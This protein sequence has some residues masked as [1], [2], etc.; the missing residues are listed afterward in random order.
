MKKILVIGSINVDF[1]VSTKV[2]PQIGETVMGEKMTVTYGG[3]GANQ[4]VAA[5]RLGANVSMIGKVGDDSIA[6]DV[7]SNLKKNKVS[8]EHIER[9]KNIET[10]SAHITLCDGDNSIIVIP[11]A[12]AKYEHNFIEKYSKIILAHTLVILQNEIPAIIVEAIIEFCFNN[13]IKT[14]YNPAPVRHIALD[15]L[16]KATYITPNESEFTLLFKDE[17]I[18][19]VLKKYPN[20]VI[21]TLGPEGLVYSNGEKIVKVP[22]H[23]TT[24]VDTT[25][26]GDTF[27]GA[28]ATFITSNQTFSQAIQNANIAAAIS[29]RKLGAQE[30]MPT[31]EEVESEN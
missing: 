16:V 29:I 12:N 2:R 10:G 30:G 8:T 11:A 26:A 18:E 25:G 5:A 19:D 3:K 28:F 7:L 9:L 4:A 13:N 23:K 14:L 22:A 20:Q 27:N 24:V 21:V 17:K 31:L 6:N 15:T 1:V